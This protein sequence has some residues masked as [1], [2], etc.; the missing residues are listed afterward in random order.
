MAPGSS[1]ITDGFRWS[2]LSQ[3]MGSVINIVTNLILLTLLV[4][5]D[6]GLVA[7]ISV[8]YGLLEVIRSLG[9][10][11]S[12]IYVKALDEEEISSLFWF[13]LIM[14]TI[15]GS[16]FYFST[17]GL[18]WFY[19]EPS[20]IKVVPFF[21]LNFM[22]LSFS[23]VPVALSNRSLRFKNIG[24]IGF[25]SQLIGNVSAIALAIQGY[26][27]YSLLW[28][29]L[30]TSMC[31]TLLFVAFSW[32]QLHFGSFSL[33]SIRSHLNFGWPLTL[34]NL[35]NFCVR[36]IDDLLIGK[37]LGV[38]PL[39][40]YNRA[41]TLML[42]PIINFSGVISKVLF[43]YIS[44]EE[45]QSNI[46]K[47]Y[48]KTIRI[49]TVIMFPMMLTIFLCADE[50]ILGILG[51][52][53]QDLVPLLRIFVILGAFQSIARLNGAM[54]QGMGATKLQLRVGIR[55]K[56]FIISMIVIGLVSTKSIVG[57]ALFYAVGSFIGMLIE[58][59]SIAGLMSSQLRNIIKA[60]QLQ[61]LF[62][63]ISGAVTG[64]V[65]LPVTNLLNNWWEFLLFKA[66]VAI[67]TF[68]LLLYNFN[69]AL[70]L[71]TK[72]YLFVFLNSVR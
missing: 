9:S 10:G 1:T 62:C 66:T 48:V 4:P 7:M 67:C 49:I 5:D 69:R 37:F 28:R 57:I 32:R 44:K 12:V 6:F 3:I 40:F 35:L 71:E 51:N 13:N 11:S 54:F 18:I 30:L 34:D 15:I 64:I 8:F 36:N 56:P 45:Q 19:N 33:R 43:P 17:K 23:E 42:F 24:L 58:W 25:F 63:L 47:L 60:F 55:V 72:R 61:L 46:K 70:W 59:K 65:L 20:L 53:W 2:F 21:A 26:S 38:K 27:F 68:L 16:L 39:G 31:S 14:G 29:L 41:Y 22:I 50:L 52:R